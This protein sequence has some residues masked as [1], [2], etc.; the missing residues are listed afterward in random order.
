MAQ[1]L[2]VRQARAPG[3]GPPAGREAGN[4]GPPSPSR[5]RPAFLAH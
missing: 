4:A 1:P 2:P 3:S 5:L